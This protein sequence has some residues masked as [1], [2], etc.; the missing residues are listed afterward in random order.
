MRHPA[1]TAYYNEFDPYAAA[2]LRNLI[3]AGLIPGVDVD[4][5]DMKEVQPNDLRDYTQCHFL[6]GIGG[7]PHALD[8]AGWGDRPVWTGSCPCQ[9]LS[10][11]GQRKGHVDE[12][13][14]WPAFHNLIGECRP[15]TVFGEQVASKDGREW[16]AAVRADL[17]RMGYAC[18]G[19]DMPAAG[20]GAPHIRQRL[21]WV[22]DAE[23]A[24][25]AEAQSTQTGWAVGCGPN[26]GV[27]DAERNQR[28]AR[29]PSDQFR[30][31][32]APESSRDTC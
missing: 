19:A 20:V 13:H 31:C 8:I 1:M 3:S 32:D 15:A 6:A 26:G 30:E 28:E 18:G 11:A 21:W 9:P 10:S 12:R 4:D 24:K 14:L 22:A 29:R 16:F 23:S 2:W 7:W 27:A 5:R 17:E 25:Q